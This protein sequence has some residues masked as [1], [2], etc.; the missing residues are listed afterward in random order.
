MLPKAGAARSSEML[1]IGL[2]LCGLC[3]IRCINVLCQPSC[4]SKPR[5]LVCVYSGCSPATQLIL[6]CVAQLQQLYLKALHCSSVALLQPYI[7]PEAF[8]FS[9]CIQSAAAYSLGTLLP[10]S[11]PK[12]PGGCSKASQQLIALVHLGF[13]QKNSEPCPPNFYLD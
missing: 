6:L 12:I 13:F 11:S 8:A 1:S 9:A 2:L 5:D 3:S 10:R 7:T 4:R